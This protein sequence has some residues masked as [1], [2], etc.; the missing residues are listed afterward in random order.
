MP[1]VAPDYY[2]SGALP[3]QVTPPTSP[4]ET[5]KAKVTMIPFDVGRLQRAGGGVSNA[6]AA[7]AMIN[8]SPNMAAGAT[9]SSAQ[10]NTAAGQNQGGPAAPP[11]QAYEE[12]GTLRRTSFPQMSSPPGAA[13]TTLQHQVSDPSKQQPPQ[14]SQAQKQQGCEIHYI[15][16]IVQKPTTQQQ[17]SNQS[18]SQQQLPQQGAQQ[19]A[20]QTAPPRFATG[21][22]A[23]AAS[24]PG[25][26]AMPQ[27]MMPSPQGLAHQQSLMSIA[28]RQQQL[29]ATSAAIQQQQQRLNQQTAGMGL[30]MGTMGMGMN[31]GMGGMGTMGMGMGAGPMMSAGAGAVGGGGFLLDHSMRSLSSAA[32]AATGAT[33]M[34]IARD[35]DS[36]DVVLNDGK[37]DEAVLSKRPGNHLFNSVVKE[38]RYSYWQAAR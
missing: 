11:S 10:T 35:I 15:P 16:V 33:P 1:V 38:H 9:A 29:A 6:T 22:G 19:Q 36:S 17:Q 8:Q 20:T 7:A 24:M 5:S 37:R 4:P 18:Q 28:A 23:T 12:L 2:Y 14:L 27:Q 21:A 32:S 26:G 31:M 25:A 13:L 30:G 34:T 3:K